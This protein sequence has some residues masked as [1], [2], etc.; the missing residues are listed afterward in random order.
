MNAEE[1]KIM[2]STLN[3][4]QEK[5][6]Q[7]LGVSWSS[8][9]RWERGLSKPSPLALQKIKSLEKECFKND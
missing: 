7:I 6:A 8:I 4:T 3:M 9:T 5:L 2:R 1:I